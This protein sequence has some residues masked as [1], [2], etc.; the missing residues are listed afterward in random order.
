MA[1]PAGFYDSSSDEYEEYAFGVD[2]SLEKGRWAASTTPQEVSELTNNLQPR[3]VA[4]ADCQT[5]AEVGNVEVVQR[6]LSQDG[7]D[8][9]TILPSGWTALLHAANSAQPATTR[10]LLDHNANANFH[11]NMF[12][13]LMGAC[14]ATGRDEP[15]AECVGLLLERGARVNAHDHSKTTALM[16]AAREGRLEAVHLLLKY[17]ADVNRQDSRGWS[18]LAWTTHRG[19]T[20]VVR[21]LLD[22]GADPELACNDGQSPLD[23]AYASDH[24]DIIDI[25]QSIQPTS[26]SSAPVDTPIVPPVSNSKVYAKYG[27]LE[28]FLCG[29]E[30]GSLVPL[31]Q[32]HQVDLG[33]LLR[34]RDSDLEKVGISQVGVRRKVL[35]AVGQLH[36]KEW[37]VSNL[38][39]QFATVI[40][41]DEATVILSNVSKHTSYISATVEYVSKQIA[42]NPQLIDPNPVVETTQ[43]FTVNLEEACRSVD[44][45]K[46]KM[47]EL[48]VEVNFITDTNLNLEQTN[49]KI[50][51]WSFVSVGVLA[52]AI[53]VVG[54][55]LYSRLSGN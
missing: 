19:Y 15:V 44:S 47:E 51:T 55:T 46:Q 40:G 9:D 49:A 43:H 12:T 35:E 36:K 25:L 48:K 21:C 8:V 26:M 24:T 39:E 27:D 34:M 38:D 29:L 3:T 53:A 11:K 1:V 41:I 32:Q 17:K 10:L 2:S 45:L 42:A 22:N 7:C 4:L 20:N 16:F 54:H 37:D 28:L 30:L 18:A 6:Y 52:V 5:A 13:T 14:V 33:T 50:K 31:F 23:L